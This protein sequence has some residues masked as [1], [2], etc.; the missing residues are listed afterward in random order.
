MDLMD[1]NEKEL[2]CVDDTNKQLVNYNEEY[3]V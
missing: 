1:L 3:M 2:D